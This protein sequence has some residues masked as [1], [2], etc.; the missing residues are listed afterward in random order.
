[1]LSCMQT[2]A[3]SQVYLAKYRSLCEGMAGIVTFDSGPA[4]N[5]KSNTFNVCKMQPITWGAVC[6]H[7]PRMTCMQH[8]ASSQA[9][10][11]LRELFR[12][13]QVISITLFESITLISFHFLGGG[14]P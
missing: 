4:T 2:P 5:T 3:A 6:V 7:R 10:V 9:N 1:M 11:G 14:E 12:T 8:D 13:D